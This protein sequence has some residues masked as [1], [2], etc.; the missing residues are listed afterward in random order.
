MRFS[1][2][3]IVGLLIGITATAAYHELLGPEPNEII[4]PARI[5]ANG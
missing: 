1:L 4:E 5:G 2:G 3:F